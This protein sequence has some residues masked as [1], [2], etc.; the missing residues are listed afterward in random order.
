MDTILNSIEFLY[1]LGYILSG[2]AI[3]IIG[4]FA[5]KALHP[6]IDIQKE[7]VEKDNFAFILSYVGYF[8][9]LTIAIGGAIVGESLDFL[10]DIQHIFIYGTLSIPLLL[11]ASWISNNIILRKFDLKKEILI[12]RNEGTGIIEAAIYITN[13]LLLF[14]ALLGE[15]ESLLSGLTTFVIYWGIGNL[16][17]ILASKIFTSWMRYDIHD[18]IEKDNIAAGV[19]FAGALLAIGIITMNAILDP[20]EDWT[21]TL[22]DISI[23][24][25]LG[26]VLLPFM[27]VFADKI[28][29]PGRS[30][31]DEIINQEKPNIGAG[32]IEAFAYTAS[33]ILITWSI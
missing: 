6:T 29:L 33:A 22:I 3:F 28:L 13:G 20:F 1:S 4:K 23:Q 2:F 12:D 7:L 27:R 17:L 16:V 30:L 31:T 18:A 15:S 25:I 5:Y 10:T 26:I 8:I 9:A 24:S 21:T 11:L 32:L 14:G 19:S